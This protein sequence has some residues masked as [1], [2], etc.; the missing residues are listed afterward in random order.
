MIRPLYLK[1]RN[2]SSFGNREVHIDFPG[3]GETML[4]M[5]DIGSGKSSI[6]HALAYN[7]TGKK[8]GQET[9]VNT[10]NQKDMRTEVA[11]SVPGLEKPLIIKR[12]MKPSSFEVTG[13]DGTL[14]KEVAGQ[15]EKKLPI[16][17]PQVMLNLCLLSATKSLPFFDLK[18]Q[19]R[20]QF[21]RNFVDTTK[22]D[23]L[24]DKAKDINLKVDRKTDTL[25]SEIES[26]KEQ[27]SDIQKSIDSKMSSKSDD[28]PIL[29][30]DERKALDEEIESGLLLIKYIQND[31]A[32][33]DGGT[34]DSSLPS[35]GKNLGYMDRTE[36]TEAETKLEDLKALHHEI[37]GDINKVE[38]I[39]AEISGRVRSSQSAISSAESDAKRIE[40]P[41]CRAYFDELVEG[42]KQTLAS[43]HKDL[44]QIT[45]HLQPVTQKL[46]DT[47]LE[48][49]TLYS[50]LKEDRELIHKVKLGVDEQLI[51][52]L[53]RIK[54][55]DEN[56]KKQERIQLEKDAISDMVKLLEGTKAKL[57][58][59][60]EELA[61][62]DRLFL[63]S[64]EYR[65]IL[66]N[67]WGYMANR[68]V[69]YLNSRIPYYME[70]L[71]MDFHM[72]LDPR[73]ISN[74]IFRGRPG[75]GDLKLA[76]LSNGQKSVL[77]FC[78][79]HALRD[80]E[81]STYG[82]RIGFLAID[83]FTAAFDS[84]KVDTVMNFERRHAHDTQSALMIITH[85]VNLQNQ[86]W[87]KVI[88]IHRTN[89]SEIEVIK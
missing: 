47:T 14:Q 9:I 65:K 62:A 37:Q 86:E 53:R 7:A 63:I 88:K 35:P 73:D 42:Y 60:E 26:L 59:R 17:D 20:L 15:L 18:K 48:Y 6:L 5:G 34:F 80:L 36:R 56:R 61:S 55:D 30:E 82:V 72:V 25:R 4:I 75:V 74:P 40:S 46:S 78:L 87:D 70:R 51:P 31:L 44:Q 69:P 43:L 12:G 58:E 54:E 11:W 23:K 89:F 39:K 64:K 66:D 84:S 52:I 85:D 13:I 29:S 79:A 19:D 16:T 10:I 76:D 32:R 67:T 28:I 50:R 57:E 45:E 2:F 49:S 22:L 21:L 81:E 83:E 3:P 71:E 8:V 68:M 38:Q 77:S 1:M 27:I 24:S 33:I 41:D